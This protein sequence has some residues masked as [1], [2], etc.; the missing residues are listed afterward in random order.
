M[1]SQMYKRI[2]SVLTRTL[3]YIQTVTDVELR[4]INF[5]SH[6]CF[7]VVCVTRLLIL[8]TSLYIHNVKKEDCSHKQHN[9]IFNTHH[10]RATDGN[11]IIAAIGDNFASHLGINISADNFKKSPFMRYLGA[12]TTRR[13]QFPAL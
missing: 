7:Q 6:K 13:Y 8:L 1:V 4:K 5:S 3:K 10:P 2:V 11:A 12:N 9:D